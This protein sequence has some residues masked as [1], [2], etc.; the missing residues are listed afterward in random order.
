MYYVMRYLPIP[1][2]D[3]VRRKLS[4]GRPVHRPSSIL[5]IDS[6]SC[7]Q[8]SCTCC[9]CQEGLHGTSLPGRWLLP[10]RP[11]GVRPGSDRSGSV[12]SALR[13]SSSDPSPRGQRQLARRGRS[14]VC[15]RVCGVGEPGVA[16]QT[17]SIQELIRGGEAQ[18]W[19]ADWLQAGLRACGM[20]SPMAS[21]G[22]ALCP[23]NG[24]AGPGLAG[25]AQRSSAGQSG[26][27]DESGLLKRCV[28]VGRTR[29]R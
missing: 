16:G 2:H 7:P 26:L 23:S 15:S 20:T 18:S 21:S 12:G 10:R 13:G 22:A 1:P 17:S 5:G 3:A 6:L 29:A 9:R 8:S 14:A 27:M 11:S 4:A 19:P 28:R 24:Q 25:A